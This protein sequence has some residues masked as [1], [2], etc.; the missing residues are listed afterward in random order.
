MPT[1]NFAILDNVKKTGAPINGRQQYTA[2]EIIPGSKNIHTLSVAQE[3]C[4]K[5]EK[6]YA[7]KQSIEKDKIGKNFDAE[8][9]GNQTNAKVNKQVKIWSVIG[10]I[11][12]GGLPFWLCSKIKGIKKYFIGAP[13]VIGGAALGATSGAIISMLTAMNTQLKKIPGWKDYIE[14]QKQLQQLD[15][16]EETVSS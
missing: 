15:V 1:I 5:F 2:G 13:L 16:K 8:K 4:D 11:A 3:D 14:I 9:F 10:S 6:L 12:G 7:Q